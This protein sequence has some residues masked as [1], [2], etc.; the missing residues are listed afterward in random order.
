MDV[1]LNIYYPPCKAMKKNVSDR[2]L[3]D[4]FPRAMDQAL[5]FEEEVCESKFVLYFEC[6]EGN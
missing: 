3:V 2:F 4:G 1:D 5:K 6:P